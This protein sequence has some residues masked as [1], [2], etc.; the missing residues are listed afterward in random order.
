MKMLSRKQPTK[1]QNFQTP[2]MNF[3][4]EVIAEISSENRIDR[5]YILLGN[6]KRLQIIKISYCKQQFSRGFIYL[7]ML[8]CGSLSSTISTNKSI[9]NKRNP[10]KKFAVLCSAHLA[11]SEL[12]RESKEAGNAKQ[13]SPKNQNMIFFHPGKK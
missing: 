1:L 10:M 12:E 2:Q 6:F 5:L 4:M 3:F 13:K 7:E 11:L 8:S 9:M